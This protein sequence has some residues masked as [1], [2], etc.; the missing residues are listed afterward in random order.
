MRFVASIGLILLSMPILSA[1]SK[2]ARAAAHPA[3]AHS[4]IAAG[5][6]AVA[7]PRPTHQTPFEGD[8]ELQWFRAGSSRPTTVIYEVKGNRVRYEIQSGDRNDPFAVADLSTSAAF[9]VLPGGRSYVALRAPTPGD[10]SNRD[11]DRTV[12]RMGITGV[13]AGLPCE[14]WRITTPQR[15]VDVCAA[16]GIS[17][18]DLAKRPVTGATEPSWAVPLTLGHAFPLRIIERDSRG[19]ELFHLEAKAVRPRALDDTVFRVPPGLHKVAV[20]P[21]EKLPSIS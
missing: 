16:H 11:L 12:W 20:H 17:Y 9:G 2:S 13:V 5:P 6:Q 10:P 18:F 4:A 8:I 19:K 3:I 15:Q 1:C 7:A 14:R 21:W